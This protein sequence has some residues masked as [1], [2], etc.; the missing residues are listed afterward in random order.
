MTAG[1][2][3]SS[4][5]F[6]MTTRG[7]LAAGRKPR[8][9]I[10]MKRKRLVLFGTA[11]VALAAMLGACVA[12]GPHWFSREKPQTD[13]A[14]RAEEPRTEVVISSEKFQTMKIRSVSV[15]QRPVQEERTVP[16]QIEY[17]RVQRV[18]LKAPVDSVV[19]KVR[20]KPG[21]VVK[22]GTHLA[23][24]TSP[25]VG[26]A[27]AEV[28]KCQ[29]E[30]KI[31]NQA[32]EWSEEITVNLGELLKFL[33]DKP[34]PEE[35]E[36]QFDE[37]VLGEHRQVVLSAYSKCRLAEKMW[38]S[39]QPGIKS[40]SLP[41][42]TIRQFESNRDVAKENYLS[43]R[44][45]SQFDA[46][47]AREKA[48]QN[49]HYAKRLVDV[50]LQKLQTLLGAFSKVASLADSPA[51]GAELTRFYLIAPLDGTLEE[52]LT[53]DSQR[54]TEG[55]LLFTVA[56]TETLE[57]SAKIREGD[58]QAVSAFF[59]AG[60]A[61]Q[62]VLKVSVPAVGEER[63]FEATVDYVGNAV[64]PVTRSFPLVAILDNSKH[65]F[66]PGMF[67]RIKIPAGNTTEELVV[68]PGALRTEDQ[69]DFVFVEDEYEPRKFHRVDVKVG[70]HT[71]D[72]VTIASGLTPGQ[73]VVVEG[74]FLLKSELLLEP[75][76]E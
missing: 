19:E 76:E 55:T 10:L 63:E 25:D 41:E 36:E 72:W 60:S 70:R 3:S 33:R 21:D 34:Q 14:T 20:V 35:V 44:E 42:K 9:T 45:Q 54:V 18:E 31:A 62:R 2:H 40:G 65:E 32:L 71:P 52:R 30:L 17:R 49:Q 15:T 56:N 43:V 69:H 59:N 16:G 75:E 58:W 29:S 23:N 5:G 61:D 12:W 38:A 48:R 8:E 57:V 11:A 1:R 64:D 51:N 73:R 27:R 66:K 7:I 26:L 37:K 22:P 28:E 67:A 13:S 53:A 39:I 4:L 24:L 47:Q 74:A 6:V 68:P 50:S 46:R